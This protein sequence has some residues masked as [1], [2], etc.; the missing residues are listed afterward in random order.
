M[1]NATLS[2]RVYEQIRQRLRAGTLKPGARLVN[3]TLAAELG[4]STIP[5]REAIS[6]LIS[7][8]LVD[9]TP[10]G[11][12]FVRTPDPNELAELYD[13]REVLEVL[14]AGE[15][16]RYVSETMIVEFRGICQ[17]FRQIA[18]AIAESTAS[19]E[20]ASAT[21]KKH[22]TRE[23]LDRW[24]DVE[25]AFHTRLVAASRNRW[26]AKTVQS[27]RVL[28]DLFA[29]QRLVPELLTAEV[30]DATARDH[31]EFLEILRN[32]DVDHAKAW[33]VLHI[34]TGRATVLG[35][36]ANAPGS[37][38]GFRPSTPGEIA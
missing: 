1:E 12:A 23:Q 22:A 21:A 14:A 16:T 35:Q 9:A 26:L 15:A 24:L 13:V 8:G 18:D 36:L 10:G 31:A 6:R 32:R 38:S 20:V 2:Q 29:A 27:V 25:E 28:S 17:Q 37:R 34:R 5:V 19:T 3:R 30:A 4:T 7:E 11:G 33:M